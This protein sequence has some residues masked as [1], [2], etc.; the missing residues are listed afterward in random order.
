MPRVKD[1]VADL[2]RMDQEA[3]IAHAIWQVG[4]V[5]MV[6]KQDCNVDLTDEQCEEILEH[7]DGESGGGI[8]DEDIAAYV[9]NLE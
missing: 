4:D 1:V 6:A 7:L 5:K 2:L 8:S 9:D 3:V